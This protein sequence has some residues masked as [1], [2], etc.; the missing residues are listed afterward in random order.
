MK[1]HPFLRQW[2][3]P[4]LMS[5]LILSGLLSALLGNGPWQILSRIALTLPIFTVTWHTFRKS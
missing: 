2:G 4:L 5:T 1:K 3:M